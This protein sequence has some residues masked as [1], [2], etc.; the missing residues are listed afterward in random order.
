IPEGAGLDVSRRGRRVAAGQHARHHAAAERRIP[1]VLRRQGAGRAVP[2]AATHA[3][4]QLRRRVQDTARGVP[5]AAPRPAARR[6]DAVRPRRRG[7]D[8]VA[9]VYAASRLERD[10]VSVP[11]RILGTGGGACHRSR[12]GAAGW[13]GATTAGGGR[14]RVTAR[15]VVVCTDA[16]AVS[17]AA[18]DAIADAARQAMDARGHFS[19]ALSGGSTPRALYQLLATEYL[20]RI[21]WTATDIFFGD[22]RCVPPDHPD[23]NFRMARESLIDHVPGLA[24]RAHR[25]AGELPPAD[26]ATEYEGLLRTTFPGDDP[27]TFD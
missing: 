6:S 9:R 15:E 22:E 20:E 13:V 1:L 7:G 27:V 17:R 19:I 24:A 8:V 5:D 11:G 4:F 23:S 16:A 25:I 26:A 18:A 2:F 14:G 10:A 12:P 3:P 21:P